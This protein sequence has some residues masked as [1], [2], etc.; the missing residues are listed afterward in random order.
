MEK[1][2]ENLAR[3]EQEL[4]AATRLE[5]RVN[6]IRLA[7]KSLK[8]AQVRVST[9]EKQYNALQPPKVTVLGLE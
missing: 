6:E 1:L 4:T 5:N 7:E 3:V 2:R 8:E 9:L